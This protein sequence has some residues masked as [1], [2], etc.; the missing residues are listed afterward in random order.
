PQPAAHHQDDRRDRDRSPRPT[1]SHR[2]GHPRPRPPV[3]KAISTAPASLS[4]TSRPRT[5]KVA[6]SWATG[7]APPPNPA[8]RHSSASPGNLLTSMPSP[9]HEMRSSV[10]SA[11][12]VGG[13]DGSTVGGFPTRRRGPV[14][15][16]RTAAEDPPTGLVSSVAVCLPF[17]K[18][19]G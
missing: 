7:V 12:P 4:A 8:A 6:E 13:P 17:G 10:F 5:S 9:C 14:R 16:R 15:G 1:S 11:E 19:E 2:R 3:G 18:G